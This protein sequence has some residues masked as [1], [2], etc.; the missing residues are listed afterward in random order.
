MHRGQIENLSKVLQS[1]H[2]VAPPPSPLVQPVRLKSEVRGG[3][4]WTRNMSQD[5]EVNEKWLVEIHWFA[6]EQNAAALEAAC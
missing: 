6:G 5:M 4:K 3:L 2:N 1:L